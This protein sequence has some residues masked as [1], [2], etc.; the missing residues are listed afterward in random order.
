M[1]ELAASK[2]GAAAN[3]LLYEA[4][5]AFQRRGDWV[6]SL[7]PIA[8]GLAQAN[9]DPALRA[10]L[11]AT[12]ADVRI[13]TGEASESLADLTKARSLAQQ[14]DGPADPDLLARIAI[15]EGNLAQ[16]RRDPPR[17]AAAYAAAEALASKHALPLREAEALANAARTSLED[18]D[19]D[20]A[21]ASL[22]R[23]GAIV[24]ER[25]SRELNLHLAHTHLRIA[26][27]HEGRRRKALLAANDLLTAA[28]EPDKNVRALG[29]ATRALLYEVEER[30]E[31]AI[32]LT[33][34]ARELAIAGG[35]RRPL[36]AI[37]QAQE[38]RLLRA[39]GRDDKAEPLL[40][41]AVEVLRESS[42]E[43]NDVYT[44][45]ERFFSGSIE[46][47]YRNLADLRLANATTDR[48]LWEAREI[49][50]GLR[51]ASLRDYYRDPCIQA[52]KAE[53]VDVAD[54]RPE[55]WF[56]TPFC[57]RIGSR[58]WRVGGRT[59]RRFTVAAPAA[60]VRATVL[61][62]RRDLQRRVTRRYRR[63][64]E[65]LYDWLIRPAG[66]LLDDA[67]TL[68]LVP[69][70]PLGTIPIAA[71]H[72][73]EHFLIERLPV[74]TTIGLR[75][76][77]PRP[78]DA[79]RAP[80]IAGLSK[81]AGDFG[82][83]PSVA[84]ELAKLGRL[85]SAAPMLDELFRRDALE[86]SLSESSPGFLH[87][88]THAEFSGDPRSSALAAHDGPH[89]LRRARPHHSQHTLSRGAPSSYSPQRLRDGD[90]ERAG[91]AG[92]R[93]PGTPG[94]RPQCHRHAL[95]RGRRL[96]LARDGRLL[97]EPASPPG[98][99]PRRLRCETPSSQCCESAS[100][101]STGRPS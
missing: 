85:Y 90:R 68:V 1:E 6:R 50:E 9:E 3:E 83:L 100:I 17:A 2:S 47:I 60:E 34:Q 19:V 64:A 78:F 61:R 16:V 45:R 97:R 28:P 37:W 12:R 86:S 41:Q 66:A 31:E 65:Q 101:P 77:A 79:S 23:A 25:N 7:R 69:D 4:A 15:I 33:R 81:G 29:L 95:A 10:A 43:S 38:A 30:Y 13:A 62:L 84:G 73:G 98:N 52:L 8:A 27:R 48:D 74:A 70:G 93:G 21:A 54:V 44:S 96:G 88:A 36:V 99:E 82:P 80:L 51:N 18:G 39:L 75:M 5:A 92:P 67:E 22:A 35:E 46:P 20:G 71:L 72:D 32:Q 24:A 57:S 94:R 53:T 76:V 87:I 59:I 11:L 56:S 58:S 26:D 63:S 55:P 14:G 42:P 89:P 49:V 91:R 40:H